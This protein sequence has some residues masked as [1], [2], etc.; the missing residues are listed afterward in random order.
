[1]GQMKNNQKEIIRASEIGSYIYCNRAWWLKR[2]D[3][4]E[5]RNMTEMQHGTRLH[6]RHA[7]LVS[8]AG[9]LQKIAYGLIAFA[10]FLIMIYFLLG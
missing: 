10:L 8:G 5:S 7:R 1:M 6:E 4:R 9:R 3:G 2:I